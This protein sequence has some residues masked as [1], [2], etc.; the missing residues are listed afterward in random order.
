MSLFLYEI[1]ILFNHQIIHNALKIF[2]ILYLTLFNLLLTLSV[3]DIKRGNPL[4]RGKLSSLSDQLNF[5]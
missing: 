1:L 5:K 2:V 4:I 3:G